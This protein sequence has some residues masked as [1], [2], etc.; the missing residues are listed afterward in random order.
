[1]LVVV[2]MRFMGV[3]SPLNQIFAN[4][5][6]R[7]IYMVSMVIYGMGLRHKVSFSHNY[8]KYSFFLPKI[9]PIWS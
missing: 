9:Y 7:A 4:V 8:F 3:A 1:L 5:E 2:R 6:K